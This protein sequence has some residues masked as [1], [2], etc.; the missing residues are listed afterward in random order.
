MDEFKRCVAA[1]TGVKV[2]V[3]NDAATEE[4]EELYECGTISLSDG[5]SRSDQIYDIN[6][7]GAKGISVKLE[8]ESG[9]ITVFE[10]EVFQ[11]WYVFI[12][13]KVWIRAIV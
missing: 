11:K 2:L 7:Y 5:L 13:K 6:C 10:L 8:K 1:D 4:N 3:Y 9:V 12:K